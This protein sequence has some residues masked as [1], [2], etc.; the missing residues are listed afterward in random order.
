[1]S[2]RNCRFDQECNEMLSNKDEHNDPI[3]VEWKENGNWT[4]SRFLD[5]VTKHLDLFT[6]VD[7]VHWTSLDKVIFFI[8]LCFRLIA[9]D[10]FYFSQKFFKY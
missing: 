2:I 10:K 5:R 1:M 8:N 9:S 6:L 3:F 7:N 4:L